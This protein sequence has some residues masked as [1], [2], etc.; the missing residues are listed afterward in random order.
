MMFVLFATPCLSAKVELD[1]FQSFMQTSVL[2]GSLGISHNIRLQAGIAF[3]DH[4]R[5][6]LCHQFLN[7]F[8]D[9]TDLMFL[10]DDIGWEAQSVVRLLEH[11]EDIVGGVY[12]L[13]QDEIGFPVELNADRTTHKLI[14]KNGLV[15]ANFLPTGFMRLKRHAIELMAADQPT[16]PHR[17]ADGTT[18]HIKNIFHTGYYDGERWGEDVDFANRWRAKGGHMWVDPEITLSH[19][20]RKRWCASFSVAVDAA[21]EK[22]AQMELEDGQKTEV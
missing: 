1:F 18:E 21:R 19:V 10:D 12:P 8:P 16:Y 15:Q 4:A 6:V 14:E 7:D 2:L 11:K 3:I 17:R 13:K 22:L 9:A 5:N 20:G